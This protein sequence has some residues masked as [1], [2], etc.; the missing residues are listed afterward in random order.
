MA[1]RRA[2]T[3][4]SLI[5]SY[6]WLFYGKVVTEVLRL[7]PLKTEY[8]NIKKHFEDK[9][10]AAKAMD[11]VRKRIKT[12]LARPVHKVFDVVLTTEQKER[13]LLIPVNDISVNFYE[14]VEEK[15][16]SGLTWTFG[17][18][19][20][21]E[22]SEA[23][24]KRKPG[25]I[26]YNDCLLSVKNVVQMFHKR[27]IAGTIN[28]LE[29]FRNLFRERKSWAY[30]KEPAKIRPWAAI[31]ESLGLLLA[32]GELNGQALRVR[33][34]DKGGVDQFGT[35]GPERSEEGNT[36]TEKLISHPFLRKV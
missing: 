29:N 30:K 16:A 6:T 4:K 35:V 12:T 1:P 22:S 27:R 18:L 26:S 5:P 28:G 24:S 34:L 25:S 3:R 31:L 33:N 2:R 7:D 17:L 32:D 36:H 10:E 15:G 19:K 14:T 8:K 21:D 20:S 11:H 13:L 9:A 23:H